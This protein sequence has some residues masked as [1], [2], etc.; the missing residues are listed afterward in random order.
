MREKH[1]TKIGSAVFCL[2][3]VKKENFDSIFMFMPRIGLLKK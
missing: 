1:Y 3:S 2:E